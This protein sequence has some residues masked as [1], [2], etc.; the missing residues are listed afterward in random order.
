MSGRDNPFADLDEV[1]D[2]LT[3]FGS[4]IAGQLPV[5]VLDADDELLVIADLPAREPDDI[6]VQLTDDRT[7][8]IEAAQ[9]TSD[10]DARYAMRE[11]SHEAVERSVTLPAAVDQDGTEATYD[12]GV[13]TVRLDKR[14]GEG[15]GTDIP[16]S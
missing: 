9:P 14:G 10:R 6:T 13:L 8:E 2:Q 11:R 4:V 16:V 1:V 3:Q 12:R 15:D 5:D 7:L